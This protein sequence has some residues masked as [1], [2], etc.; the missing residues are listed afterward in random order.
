VRA[1]RR[2]HGGR[3]LGGEAG[4]HIRKRTFGVVGDPVEDEVRRVRIRGSCALPRSRGRDEDSRPPIAGR[5]HERDVLDC[6][7]SLVG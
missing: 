6:G 1:D 2:F 3:H 4:C 7:E 5:A